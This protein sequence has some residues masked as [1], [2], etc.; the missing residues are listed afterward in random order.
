MPETSSPK[1]RTSLL[2]LG[3]THFLGRAVV[4]EALGRGWQ[5][6]LFNRNKTNPELF[7]GEVEKVTGDRTED[8]SVLSG[9]RFDAVVDVACYF[10]ADANRAVAALRGGCD[11]YLFVSTVS[12]YADQRVPCDEDSPTAVLEDPTDTTVKT[13]GARKAAC[14]QVVIEGFGERATIVRPGLIVGAHDPT[15][16]FGYWPRRVAAGGRV[17]CPGEPSDPVQFID[18]VDLARFMLE[19][20]EKDQPGTFNATG[21]SLDFAS[22]LDA[23]KETLGGDAEFVWVPSARLL[24]AGLEPWMGIP[25]WISDP[26]WLAA[27]RVDVSRALAA[28]LSFR[29][30]GET[31]RDAYELAGAEELTSFTPEKEARLL[32]ELA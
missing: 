6:T 10:P 32:S 15:D 7:E 26:D 12:V 27:N 21:E 16:R 11:R 20:V 22:L 9:R 28:G 2:V 23:C 24:E 13:Y 8:L 19:L 17:L 30:L 3:G 18:V 5:V 14:E 29:P 25:L 31:I 4:T 1:D